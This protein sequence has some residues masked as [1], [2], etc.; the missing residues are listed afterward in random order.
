MPLHK[1]QHNKQNTNQRTTSY[2]N[3]ACPICRTEMERYKRMSEAVD[4]PL[5]WVDISRDEN[6]N[7]LLGLGITQEMAFR[8]IYVVDAAGVPRIGVD[9]ITALWKEIP[10]L[11]IVGRLIELPIIRQVSAFLYDHI[12]SRAVYEWNRMRLRR[13]QQ[14][15]TQN[16]QNTSTPPIILSP[17]RPTKRS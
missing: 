17:K 8:R 5:D 10:G 9:G 7:A 13:E 16:P 12:L 2:Y 15:N 4:A 3:G 14:K 11:A 6:K 1:R